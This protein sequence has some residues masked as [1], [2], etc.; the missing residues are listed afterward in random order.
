M[1][2]ANAGVVSATD[3]YAQSE[4][5]APPSFKTVDVVLKGVVNT[6]YLARHYFTQADNKAECKDLI[7]TASTGGLY[8]VPYDPLYAAA[9]HG[10]VGK[11]C[12]P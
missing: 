6:A 12:V 1:V 5:S 2:Q 11:N 8:A 7:V 4:A 10:V 3:F 9:K